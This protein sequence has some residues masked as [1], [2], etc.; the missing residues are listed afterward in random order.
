MNDSVFMSQPQ[1]IAWLRLPLQQG[2]ES[3]LHALV[4]EVPQERVTGAQWK[5]SQRRPFASLSF[6]K[7]AVDDFVGSSIAAN[8]NEFSISLG[9][10][11][12]RN[13]GSV[14]DAGSFRNFDLNS[15]IPK[16]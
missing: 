2:I 1:N 8:G 16:L 9:V 13:R 11:I 14:A 15:T 6:R 12:P 7:Q 3:I 10:S 5:K 4:S